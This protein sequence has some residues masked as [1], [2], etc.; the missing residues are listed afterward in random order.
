NMF[1]RWVCRRGSCVDLGIWESFSPD[2]VLVPLDTHVH[3]M[4]LKLGITQRK[5]ADLTTAL[6][7]NEYFRNIFP[8][9]PGR[10]DFALFGYAITHPDYEKGS[11]DK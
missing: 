3:K 5:S 8:N 10:G 2:H 7:I 6:E 1:L 4:S 11:F 9:D